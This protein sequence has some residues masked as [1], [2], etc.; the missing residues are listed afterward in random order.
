MGLKHES[1][2]VDKSGRGEAWKT[3]VALDIPL[4]IVFIDVFDME[5]IL[6]VSK[7]LS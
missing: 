4:F 6:I 2:L 1:E 3:G 7:Q 5:E